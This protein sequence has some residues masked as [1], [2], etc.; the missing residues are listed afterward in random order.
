M[1]GA[2]LLL[3]LVMEMMAWQSPMAVHH[4]PPAVWMLLLL[5]DLSELPLL[6]VAADAGCSCRS[7]QPR[8]LSR[9]P[10]LSVVVK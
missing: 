7:P 2:E 6:V 5:K 3:M 9:P 4:S 10:R 8:V 1:F